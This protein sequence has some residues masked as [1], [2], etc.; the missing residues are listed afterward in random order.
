MSNLTACACSDD[1]SGIIWRVYLTEASSKNDKPFRRY[2]G[3]K[4]SG[5]K[6]ESL[7]GLLE[8]AYGMHKASMIVCGRKA[9]KITHAIFFDQFG[10]VIKTPTSVSVHDLFVNK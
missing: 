6:N 10:R 8:R 1:A 3:V 5:M 9:T 4:L 7:S 2:R